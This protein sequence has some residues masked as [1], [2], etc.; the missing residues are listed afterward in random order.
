MKKRA[1]PWSVEEH[2]AFLRGLKAFGKGHWKEI[3]RHFVHTRTP[4]Q[5]ASHAQK[6]FIRISRKEGAR[7][8]SIFDSLEAT[9]E[10]TDENVPPPAPAPVVEV[11]ETPTAATGFDAMHAA[12]SFWALVASQY[13]FRVPTRTHEIRRPIPLRDATNVMHAL[14][15]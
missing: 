1:S 3:S 2:T 14:L 8:K 4:T 6:Y 9:A 15:R 11:K 13:Q 5:V 10:G 12:M 7:R